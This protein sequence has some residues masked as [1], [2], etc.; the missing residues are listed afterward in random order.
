M[1]PC[2]QEGGAAEGRG[3]AGQLAVARRRRRARR[4][5][6]RQVS[7]QAAGPAA[8]WL[9]AC[10]VAGL[11]AGWVSEPCSE[12]PAEQREPRCCVIR[13]SWWRRL[14][15]MFWPAGTRITLRAENAVCVNC[16]RKNMQQTGKPPSSRYSRSSSDSDDGGRG[17]GRQQRGRQQGRPQPQRQPEPPLPPLQVCAHACIYTCNHFTPWYEH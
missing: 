13:V 4:G 17:N 7:A 1:A 12:Q 15:C 8:R 14:P 5:R 16:R 6:G 9:H 11:T 3:A 2:L 10:F